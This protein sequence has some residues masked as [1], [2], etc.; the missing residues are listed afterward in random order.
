MLLQRDLAIEPRLIPGSRRKKKAAARSL[1]VF[2]PP[3]PP[4][5]GPSG[6][7]ATSGRRGDRGLSLVCSAWG[8]PEIPSDLFSGS[9]FWGGNRRG[10]ELWLRTWKR[11]RRA[12]RIV[13]LWFRATNLHRMPCAYA[14]VSCTSVTANAKGSWAGRYLQ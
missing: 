9:F 5:S 8:D 13:A 14:A 6:R 7:R 4:P 1:A 2:F 3:H 12:H 11:T 10:S